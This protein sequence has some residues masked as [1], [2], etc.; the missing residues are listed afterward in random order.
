ME[1][2]AESVTCPFKTVFRLISV[3]FCAKAEILCSLQFGHVRAYKVAMVLAAIYRG[4]AMRQLLALLTLLFL[5]ACISNAPQLADRLETANNI[6]GAAGLTAA[7]LPL[8]PF[9]IQS[10]ARGHGESVTIYIEGD[11]FAWASR[12]RQSSDP[13][14]FNPLALRLAAG[15]P[16]PAVA[17]LARPCQYVMASACNRRH[18]GG[19]RFSE[20]MIAAMD[21]AVSAAKAN[22]GATHVHLVGFSG[23]GAVVAL[24]AARRSDVASLRTVAG[25]LDHVALNE[26]INVSPLTDSLDPMEVAASLRDLPQLHLSGSAD[27]VI[28][29][30]VA[31]N[32]VGAQGEESCAQ[33]IVLDGAGHNAGWAEAWPG[34]LDQTLPC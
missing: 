6:A 14:P 18:W 3:Q 16:A 17:Y 27:T 4:P 31:E 20:E 12:S 26:A 22:A 10:Y 19:A 29:S 28:P 25:Y 9:P 2:S 11:G 21:D 5:S 34:L 33:T 30:W 7:V 1:W 13:T 23:G 15:D 24:L 8:S 32:F